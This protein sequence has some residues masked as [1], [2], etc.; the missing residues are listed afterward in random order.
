MIDVEFDR[1]NYDLIP[2]TAIRRLEPHAKNDFYVNWLL[3]SNFLNN[4]C[5]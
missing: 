1:K 4:N 5:Y 3:F 2:A